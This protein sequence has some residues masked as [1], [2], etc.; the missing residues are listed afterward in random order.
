MYD[1]ETFREDVTRNFQANL[2]NALK[3]NNVGVVVKDMSSGDLCEFVGVPL[4]FPEL[5]VQSENQERKV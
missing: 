2:N 4:Q 5:I 3:T 1:S